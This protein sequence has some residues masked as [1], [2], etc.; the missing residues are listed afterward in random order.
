MSAWF[1]TLESDGT[2]RTVWDTAAGVE[3]HAPVDEPEE[4]WDR[5]IVS[6]EVVD[7]EFETHSSIGR[8]LL[9]MHVVVRG[10]TRAQCK[11][12][13]LALK[14]DVHATHSLQLRI[15]VDGITETYRAYRPDVSS[16]GGMSD[17]YPE[18]DVLLTWPV[19]PHPTITGTAV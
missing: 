16:P 2:L 9:P 4:T 10:A 12:R 1:E 3:L 8:L 14:A 11:G 6:N 15:V 17:V 5:A 13:Y 7:G 18:R 19:L